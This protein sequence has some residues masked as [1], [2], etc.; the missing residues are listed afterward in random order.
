[1]AVVCG[2]R[3]HLAGAGCDVVDG[4]AQSLRRLHG[5]RRRRVD[6][7]A[8]PDGDDRALSLARNLAA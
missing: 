1:M 6:L 8:Q 4:A 5:A 7:S 2:P 3:G